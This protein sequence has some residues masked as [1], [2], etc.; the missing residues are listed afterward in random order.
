MK[1]LLS[2]LLALI[3]VVSLFAAVPFASAAEAEIPVTEVVV[4]SAVF[5]E[6][7]TA[8]TLYFNTTY[9]VAPANDYVVSPTCTAPCFIVFGDK[10]Y[11]ADSARQSAIDSGLAALAAAEGAAIVYVNPQGET[12]ADTDL[13][14]YFSLMGMYSNSSTS[15]FVN[16]IAEESNWATGAVEQKILGDTGRVYVYAEGS[17]ADFAAA[18]LMKKCISS[19]TFGDG[20]TIEFDR[21]ATSVNLFNPTNIPDVAEKADLVAAVVNGP[22]GTAEKLA[23]FTDKGHVATSEVAEG[24]DPLWIANNYKSISGSYRRQAGFLAPMID[25]AAEGIVETIETYTNEAGTVWNNLVYYSKDLNVTDPANPVPL[26]VTFHGGGN[27]A[28]FQAQASEW[29]IIGKE[30]GFIT[31]AVDNHRNDTSAVIGIIDQLSKK[32]AIDTTRIYA[33]GFSMG[34]IM[35]WSLLEEYPTVFAGVAPMSGSNDLAD[36]NVH[37]YIV[38]TFYVA[39][40]TSPLPEMPAQDDKIKNTVAYA[41]EVNNVVVDYTYN[42]AANDCWGINGDLSYKVTDN[43]IFTN[44][45]LTVNLFKSEDGIYY[46]AMADASNQSHEVYGRNSWAAW[47]FLKQF[48]RNA[49]GS[50]EIDAVNYTLAS[51]D[52][53]VAGNSYNVPSV[54]PP[55][56]GDNGM[57]LYFA[58]AAVIALAG[59]VVVTS[60]KRAF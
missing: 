14:V 25:W 22:E 9:V 11:T 34:S 58:L 46:T 17:G 42:E 1:K 51:D 38:P 21:T 28:L 15:T 39:G 59:L 8:P 36:S 35:S 33:S 4:T 26:V 7:A 52:G 3:M 10:A 41:F 12:W 30:N 5:P 45:T 49:D 44:S 24:F 54:T 47:D 20:V 13:N 6:G 48:S 23:A 32:Y 19:T 57:V 2:V 16:G 29:P 56:T 53:A 40:R 43:K 31:V 60:K 18:Y 55:A 27:T 37:G 50:I